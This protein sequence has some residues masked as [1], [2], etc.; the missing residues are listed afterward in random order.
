MLEYNGVIIGLLCLILLMFLF[1]MGLMID[2][3]R[4]LKKIQEIT[5]ER[6]TGLENR[7]RTHRKV[8]KKLYKPQE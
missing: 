2:Y 7:V 3:R 5:A 1:M 6:L 4:N 8:I